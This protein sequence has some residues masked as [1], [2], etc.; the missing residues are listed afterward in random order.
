MWVPK[1]FLS[2]LVPYSCMNKIVPT[3]FLDFMAYDNVDGVDTIPGEYD[4]QTLL[5]SEK[6]QRIT[7]V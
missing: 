1:I 2:I 7:Q 5:G 4:T 6:D 3:N